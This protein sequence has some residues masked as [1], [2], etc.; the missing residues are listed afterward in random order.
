MEGLLTVPAK[1]EIPLKVAASIAVAIVASSPYKVLWAV[2]KLAWTSFGI[3][4]GVGFGL[5]LAMHVYEQ[6]Q[7]WQGDHTPPTTGPPFTPTHGTTTITGTGGTKLHSISKSQSNVLEDS[8]SYFAM[9]TLAGYTVPDKVLR[10]Q[11]LKSDSN[12]FK[13]RYPFTD[14]QVPLQ[15]GPCLLKDDWPSLPEPVTRELG[16]FVEHVMRDYIGGWYCKLDKGCVFTDESL[17]RAL[18]I[19]RDGTTTSQ[20]TSQSTTTLTHTAETT[21][22]GASSASRRMV[23][24]TLTHRTIPFLDQTYR[25]LSAAFGS[26][27]VRAE[28]VNVFSL[29]LLKWTH[30]LAHTFKQ[31]R[32]L[33]KVAQDKNETERPREVQIVREFLLAGKLHKA[34]TFGLDV[35]SLLF[36]DAN[37]VECG[38]EEVGNATTKSNTAVP[39]DANQV[40]EERLFGTQ[41]LLKE[42]ELDYNR[43]LAFRIVRAL[44]PKHEANSQVVMALVTEIF[45]SCV[46]QPL[47]SLWIPSFLNEIIVNATSKSTDAP[48]RKATMEKDARQPAK[49]ETTTQQPGTAANTMDTN[50]TGSTTA[51]NTPKQAAA[52][53]TRG[54]SISSSNGSLD[55]TGSGSQSPSTVTSTATIASRPRTPTK[56]MESLGDDGMEQMPRYTKE[57]GTLLLK[58]SSMAISKVE[59][60]IPFEECRMARRNGLSNSVD[61]DDPNCQQTIIRLVL[62]IEAALLHGRC[63]MRGRHRKNSQDLSHVDLD[64]DND[65]IDEDEDEQDANFSQ[66][67]MELTS[68][69]DAFERRISRL[70]QNKQPIEVEADSGIDFVPDPN[71]L[72]TIRTLISTWFHTACKCVMM[73]SRWAHSIDKLSDTKCCSSSTGHE[74][75]HPRHE[76]YSSSFLR[77]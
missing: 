26:L 19:Q 75:G 15:K 44:L 48:E 57:I 51:M 69:M 10:G 66:I 32:H 68:D 36:A 31:Y 25:V 28:H 9:M 54:A 65:D 6:L 29:A 22:A 50:T 53:T 11:V 47:M 63:A 49:K 59:G 71:E 20:S 62:V 41:D 13:L 8:S 74:S 3:A 72:S 61:Y 4:V 77:R 35:P 7:R 23:Y 39:R 30:V 24:S 67:L 46:L 73:H 33:R 70:S 42:C 60:I 27:A 76:Q 58:L 18:G 55:R 17:K 40:L 16:R 45:G 56:G 21:E 38:T 12:F 64:D 37:G 34:V 1:Y 14:V 2:W 52:A 43:C 5:G